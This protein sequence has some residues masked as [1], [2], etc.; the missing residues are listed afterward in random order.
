[1]KGIYN[2]DTDTR[3]GPLYLHFTLSLD[4]RSLKEAYLSNL[5][6]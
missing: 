5:T 1:M 2:S 3:M 6:A 4:D